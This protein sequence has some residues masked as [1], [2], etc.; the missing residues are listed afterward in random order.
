MPFAGDDLA[1]KAIMEGTFAYS[2]DTAQVV[3]EFNSVVEQRNEAFRKEIR[4]RL[5]AGKGDVGDRLKD[6]RP[7]M[8][9]SQ[10]DIGEDGA[11]DPKDGKSD[12]EAAAD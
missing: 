5:D 2:R 8:N 11:D 1:L 4:K 12:M 9:F 10:E 3:S 7:S 6:D